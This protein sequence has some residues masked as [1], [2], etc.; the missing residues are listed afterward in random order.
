MC[1]L[2]FLV[3]DLTNLLITLTSPRGAFAPKNVSSVRSFDRLV[4]RRF[5]LENL[6]NIL[7]MSLRTSPTLPMVVIGEPLNRPFW[8]LYMLPRHTLLLHGNMVYNISKN[9]LRARLIGLLHL[10]G[11]KDLHT[12]V[13]RLNL[14]TNSYCLISIWTLSHSVRIIGINV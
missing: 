4:V 5:V 14:V 3:S 6:P 12:H 13:C 8:D 9:C 1:I 7:K 2:N 10:L 11:L